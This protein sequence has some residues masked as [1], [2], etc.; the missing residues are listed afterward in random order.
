MPNNPAAFNPGIPPPFPLLIP[1]ADFAPPSVAYNPLL[2]SRR[3]VVSA[4]Y[5]PPTTPRSPGSAPY[6][7]DELLPP[8][9]DETGPFFPFQP[10]ESRFLPWMW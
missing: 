4:Y 3:G 1:P 2:V 10:G 9:D 7:G 8:A 6:P 5:V